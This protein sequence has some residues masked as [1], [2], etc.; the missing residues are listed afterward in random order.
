MD[1]KYVEMAAELADNEIAEGI[2]RSRRFFKPR[3]LNFDGLCTECG[4]D[5]PSGRLKTGACTCIDCQEAL[6]GKARTTTR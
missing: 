6:E 4:G 1:E 2:S 3:P 5:I